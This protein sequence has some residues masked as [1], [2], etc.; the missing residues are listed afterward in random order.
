MNSNREFQKFAKT[1]FHPVCTNVS[2]IVSLRRNW[3]IVYDLL[4]ANKIKF[5]TG[6]TLHLLL[7]SERRQQWH[8]TWLIFF[9]WCRSLLQTI[10]DATSTT[11]H[12]GIP[13]TSQNSCLVYRDSP[14]VASRASESFFK[15]DLL[16]FIYLSI[17]TDFQ[18]FSANFFSPDEI[19]KYIT[20]SF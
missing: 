4:T 10:T 8:S 17:P 12:L 18:N 5:H 19:Q 6:W 20:A 16:W 15:D 11:G 9:T 13:L 2:D 1:I 7:S 14:C 3:S